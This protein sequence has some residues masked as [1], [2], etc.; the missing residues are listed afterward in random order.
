MRTVRKSPWIISAILILLL[1]GCSSQPVDV[2]MTQV[3]TP[4]PAGASA[5]E[6]PSRGMP[7]YPILLVDLP[8]YE[9]GLPVP[10]A[11]SRTPTAAERDFDSPPPPAPIAAPLAARPAA[12]PAPAVARPARPPVPPGPAA[13]VTA[14][15]PAPRKTDPADIRYIP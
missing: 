3:G 14:G 4:S 6:Y 1:A 8:R 12:S 5:S 11:K 7:S 13:T 15:P 10:P 2:K 9:A